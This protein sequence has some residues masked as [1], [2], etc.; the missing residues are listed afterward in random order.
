MELG[1]GPFL[2]GA[3]AESRLKKGQDL[4]HWILKYNVSIDHQIVKIAYI[5]IN[6]TYMKRSLLYF[7]NNNKKSEVSRVY[8]ANNG[9]YNFSNVRLNPRFKNVIFVFVL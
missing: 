4:Q 5:A 1:A 8:L 3:D 6:Y 7:I 9:K 2:E